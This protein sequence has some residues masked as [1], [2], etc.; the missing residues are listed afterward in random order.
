M[1]DYQAYIAARAQ[2][3]NAGGFEPSD[4]PGHL[5]DFQRVIVEW[6]VRQGRAAI[7]ADCG[8]GK[9]PTTKRCGACGGSA[10]PGR[11]RW[12]TGWRTQTYRHRRPDYAKGVI[13]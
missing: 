12:R 6:A 10:K 4:L 5:F 2:L 7:F 11:C 1:T 8:L 3:A 9:T 13:R